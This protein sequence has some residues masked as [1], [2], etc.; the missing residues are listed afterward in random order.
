MRHSL[1][2]PKSLKPAF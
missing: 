2:S 1:K